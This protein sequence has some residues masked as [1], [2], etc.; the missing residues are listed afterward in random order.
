[1]PKPHGCGQQA[2]AV[3]LHTDRHRKRGREE[4]IEGGEEGKRSKEARTRQWWQGGKSQVERSEAMSS[5]RPA[6]L[7]AAFKS[8]NV[9]KTLRS[10]SQ[11][12]YR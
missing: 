12:V 5:W 10:Y 4:K 8:N 6:H 11:V 1:M 7:K 2:V 3:S 9:C